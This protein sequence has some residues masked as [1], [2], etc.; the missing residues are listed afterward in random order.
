V[1]PIR[2][3]ALVISVAAAFVAACGGSSSP[4]PSSS[5][6]PSPGD[7][8]QITGR[9]R[10]G[11]SQSADDISPL[12]FAVYV[13]GTRVDLPGAACHGSAP[14]FDCDSPLPPL[15]AGRHVLEV[16]AWALLNGDTVESPK[17]SPLIVQ[18]TGSTAPD[19]IT[20]MTSPSV[21]ASPKAAH[22][23]CG[24]APISDDRL[25]LW[26]GAGEIRMVDRASL[27]TRT[28]TIPTLDGWE[29]TGVGA[30]SRFDETG[31]IYTVQTNTT[32]LRLIRYRDVD[33]VLGE[34]A[35]LRDVP[36]SVKPQRAT[37]AMRE[38]D[39]IYIALLSS[40]TADASPR[41]GSFLLRVNADGSIPAQNPVG[42]VYV[43]IPNSPLPLAVTWGPDDEL[44]W[45][46]ESAG[47]NTYVLTRRGTA[48]ASRPFTA[49]ATPVAIQIDALKRLLVVDADGRVT[50]FTRT[51]AGWTIGATR[52]ASTTER[53]GN[54]L[55]FPDGDLITC[56]TDQGARY[57]VRRG[58][59]PE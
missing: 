45:R 50:R 16:V 36:L 43:S 15:G 42:S 44:P 31:W 10:F 32:D 58:S 4:P 52:A 49:P 12:H 55:L 28:L 1:L 6:S 47:L 17:A 38:A 56:G 3:T 5:P 18:V 37:V 39:R 46:V 23:T 9:E 24:L 14:S 48:I 40:D 29:L 7:A 13:D 21:A 22:S 11:W 51:S 26:T 59:V 53:T 27:T 57:V 8:I 35:V 34:A 33:G 25:L 30:H 54:A 19:A 20:S 2:A 41:D